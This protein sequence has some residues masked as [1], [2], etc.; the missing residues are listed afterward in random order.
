MTTDSEKLAAKQKKQWMIAAVLLGIFAWS[1]TT[2]VLFL[3]KPALDAAAPEGTQNLAEDLVFVT[4]LRSKDKQFADQTS[5][6]EKEW[7]RDPFEPQATVASIVKAVNLTLK[8]ILWDEAHPKA[9]V[10]E[11]TL[12]SGDT[13]YGYSVEEIKPRSVILKTGEKRIELTVFHP[14]ASEPKS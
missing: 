9:I 11:K 1:F 10:N 2:N 8:G 3:K 7:G 12:V 4:N 13:I 14:I 6:W 5:V